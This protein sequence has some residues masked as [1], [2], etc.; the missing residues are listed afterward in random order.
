MMSP[1]RDPAKVDGAIISGKMPPLPEL[2][3]E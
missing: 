2:T 1:W 3:S